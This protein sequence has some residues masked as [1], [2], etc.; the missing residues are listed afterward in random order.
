MKVK[1]ILQSIKTLYETTERASVHLSNGDKMIVEKG[2]IT[3]FA[4]VPKWL[5][6][7]FPPRK[8]NEAD[9]AFIVHDY[10]YRDGWYKT[11]SGKKVLVTRER[12]D[13]EMYFLQR[14]PAIVNGQKHGDS[15]LRAFPMWA[16]VRLF[17]KKYWKINK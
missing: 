6:W 11:S 5:W 1:P 8:G 7:L 10:L 17:G 16:A 14:R 3:D 13:Y 4:S 9:I 15:R 2:F 12:A